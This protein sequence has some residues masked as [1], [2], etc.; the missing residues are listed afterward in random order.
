M[1]LKIADKILDE[2]LTKSELA[3]Q[4]KRSVRSV[5]RWALMGEG[6]PFIRIGRRSLYRRGAVVEW[7]RELENKTKRSRR[8]HPR[9]GAQ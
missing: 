4:L 6:P 8:T 9:G 2:Y 3:A 5:D 1:E 7:L